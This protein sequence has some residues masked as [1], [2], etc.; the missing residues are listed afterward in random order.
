MLLEEFDEFALDVNPIA[1]KKQQIG[2][3]ALLGHLREMKVNLGQ[4][5]LSDIV[6]LC[7]RTCSYDLASRFVAVQQT[8]EE[9]RVVLTYLFAANYKA[10]KCRRPIVEIHIIAPAMNYCESAA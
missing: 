8:L 3:S 1:H 4:H 6:M 10:S 7:A 9:V 2:D 5:L